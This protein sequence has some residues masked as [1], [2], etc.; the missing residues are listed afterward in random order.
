ME[1]KRRRILDMFV[2]EEGEEINEKEKKEDA[3]DH[4]SGRPSIETQ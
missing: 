4:S 3:E 1:E 2:E